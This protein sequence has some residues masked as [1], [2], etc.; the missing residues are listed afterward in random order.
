MLSKAFRITR[1]NRKIII[2]FNTV[3]KVVLN[4]KDIKIYYNIPCFEFP[5]IFPEPANDV[6]YYGS[7]EEA[8]SEFNKMQELM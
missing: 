8:L 2:N 3:S 5:F 1:G 4:K 7:E 6:F